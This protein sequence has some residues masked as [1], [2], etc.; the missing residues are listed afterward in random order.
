VLLVDTGIFVA[1]GDG[2]EPRHGECAAL[3][4][5]RNDLTVTAS[6]IPEA[7]WL[8]E[9]RLG[10]AAEASFLA[11]VTSPRITILD[12]IDRDYRRTIEL[13]G[14]YADLGLGFVDASIVA[15]AERRGVTEIATLNRRDFAV[16]RPVHCDAF[17]LLP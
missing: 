2:D 13:I 17:E 5:G 15:I 16:V 4:R 3:L 11:L 12:L 9:A 14:A 8:I 1:A 10:T 7:A 6:V